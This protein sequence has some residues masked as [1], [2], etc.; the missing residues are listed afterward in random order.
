MVADINA[1][2][3]VTMCSIMITV[4]A[5]LTAADTPDSIASA[6]ML[7]SCLHAF[8][9]RDQLWGKLEGKLRCTLFHALHRSTFV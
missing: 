9:S 7:F 1:E 5:F 4:Y 6:H 2:M 8:S 3:I